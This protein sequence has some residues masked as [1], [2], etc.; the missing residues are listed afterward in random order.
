M[1]SKR[2][3]ALAFGLFTASV[4]LAHPGVPGHVHAELSASQQ[5]LHAAM[6]WAPVLIV[7]AIAGIGALRASRAE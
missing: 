4:A 6:N 7:A 3:T 2:I 1:L 5:L